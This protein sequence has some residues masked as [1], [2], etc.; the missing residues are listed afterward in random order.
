MDTDTGDTRWTSTVTESEAQERIDLGISPSDE[1]WNSTYRMFEDLFADEDTPIGEILASKFT[2]HEICLFMLSASK[3]LKAIQD[4]NTARF[5]ALLQTRLQ[6]AAPEIITKLTMLYFGLPIEP[7]DFSLTDMTY[8]MEIREPD[9][10]QSVG[11]RPL[12]FLTAHKQRNWG[13]ESLIGKEDQSHPIPT[14]LPPKILSNLFADFFSY[15]PLQKG[16]VD[17]QSENTVMRLRGGGIDE[18]SDWEM[19]GDGN[20]WEGDDGDLSYA[21]S[22]DEDGSEDVDGSVAFV[23]GDQTT[24]ENAIRRLLSLGPQDSTTFH[25]CHFAKNYSLIDIIADTF[26]LNTSSA[27]MEY[28]SKQDLSLQ[29]SF[30]IKLGDEDVPDH[31]EPS[32]AQSACE[33]AKVTWRHH[34]DIAMEPTSESTG[35]ISS[36]YLEFPTPDCLLT[37]QGHV[38][39]WNF[40]H[41]SAYVRAAF[42]V[43][44]GPLLGSFHH[45]LF[46]MDHPGID[47]SSPP[48]YGFPAIKSYDMKKI[49]SFLG[50]DTL[51]LKCTRL[52]GNEIAFFLPSYYNN[53]CRLG[54]ISR[55]EENISEALKLIW[56]IISCAF[57][58]EANRL[59][60]IRLL[61]GCETFG[62][63]TNRNQ[64]SYFIQLHDDGSGNFE[65]RNASVLSEFFADGGNF[66]LLYPEWEG[67]ITGL[68]IANPNG[69]GE[70]PSYVQ[71]PP[72]SSTVDEFRI[73]VFELMRLTGYETSQTVSVRSG[74]S[75]ISIQPLPEDGYI[76]SQVNA[77]CFFI[78]FNT[79]DEEWF[80]IRARISTPKATVR[81]IDSEK[82]NWN[83][84]AGSQKTSVWGPRYGRMA[85]AHAAKKQQKKVSWA[86]EAELIP[87]SGTAGPF[88]SDHTR[89]SLE[90]NEP[91]EVSRLDWAQLRSHK[92]KAASDGEKRQKAYAT[93]PSIFDRYGLV[94]WP[95]NSGIQIPTNAPPFEHM[96]RTGP[97][98]PLVSKAILTPTEQGELQ[99]V[100]WDLRNL[101]LKRAVRCPYDGCNFSYTLN[102]ENAMKKHLKACHTARKCMWCDDTLYE[103]WDA[104]KIN[105]HIREKHKDELMQALGVSQ[106]AI[107]LFDQEGTLSVPLRR[108][109][110]R[111]RRSALAL[112]SEHVVYETNNSPEPQ[113]DNAWGFCDCCGRERNYYSN[114]E[115]IYHRSH[116]ERSTFNDANCRFCTLCGK[117]VWSSAADAHKSGKPDR[118]LSHC[119]H[120]VDDTNGLHCSGCGFNMSRLP[121][122]GRDQHQKRCRGFGVVSGRFCLYC[123]EEFRNTETQVD[124][125][126]NKAHMVACYRG[127]PKAI[128]ML[129]DPEEAAFDQ[130]QN[131]LRLQI[132]VAAITSEEEQGQNKKDGSLDGDKDEQPSRTE[133]AKE[134]KATPLDQVLAD[135]PAVI[136]T[137]LQDAV[138]EATTS[139]DVSQLPILGPDSDRHSQETLRTILRQKAPD[140][141][142][143]QKSLSAS[144]VRQPSPVPPAEENEK[145]PDIEIRPESPLFVSSISS[146]AGS[147]AGSVFGEDE[148]RSADI[149]SED[150]L[151]SDPSKSKRRKPRGRK[152]TKESDSNYQA[153]R[154]DDEEELSSDPSKSKHRKPRGRKRT[155]EDDDNY[156]AEGDGDDDSEIDEEELSSDPSKSPLGRVKEIELHHD[157]GRCCGIRRGIGSIERLPNRS[158]W[159]PANLMPKP[160][161]TLRRK[162]LR[163]YPV[164]ARTIYP[165]NATNANGTYWRSDPNNESNEAWW[166]IPWPPFR[167]RAPLPNGWE[168]PDV[169]DVPATGRTRQQ[170]QL[171]PV[172]DPTYRQGG[173][174]HYSDDEDVDD[175][176]SDK[177]DNGKRKRKR[178]AATAKKKQKTTAIVEPANV[179]PANVGHAN[180]EKAA[181]PRPVKKKALDPTYRQDND[182]QYSDDENVDDVESEKDTNGKRKRKRKATAATPDPTYR[183]GNDVR[184]S[185]E[186]EDDVESD[187]DTNGKRKRKGK[188]ITAKKKQKTTVNLETAAVLQPVKKRAP[189]KAKSQAALLDTEAQQVQ[190]G[191]VVTRRSTRKRQKTAKE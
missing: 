43:V 162:F 85:E 14:Q 164:Y 32:E 6:D 118:Q 103:H 158:G 19:P 171:K 88:E 141:T 56:Q 167:G 168:A 160:L 144:P 23:P 29:P 132:R 108:V 113:N 126:R 152:R 143:Q 96:L 117:P 119:S 95:A 15:A 138:E 62:P 93:Q 69:F 147:D 64:K 92:T 26:P 114:T 166:N 135:S 127:N 179:E 60:Y 78:D 112:A 133:P 190:E 111:L 175:V 182:V 70:A 146:E 187:K 189:K 176:E 48:E 39:S 18:D 121:Q 125:D 99:R 44:L 82:W 11:D 174:V 91:V 79:T 106:A 8:K 61:D 107:R 36:C 105:R 120:N 54:R 49:S 76:Y 90:G 186:D 177:D 151:L 184:Y 170:F 27:S 104:A 55:S 101:C 37:T 94:P 16:I 137:A 109:K 172:A 149:E 80:K 21:A 66:A 98:M 24:Y 139:Q 110:K 45:A 140:N 67:D 148:Q 30:F 50:E 123:G 178:K 169:V 154:D 155:R 89:A 81:I 71:I 159:I 84:G 136:S 52:D 1:K 75:F 53:D 17:Q 83:W 100:A 13:D 38:N 115:R 77:P 161:A 153:E 31:W 40:D 34:A 47:Y 185:D 10:P 58:E 20:D 145:E 180:F 35:P 59:R 116:C 3:V 122:A 7:I 51:E 12:Q 129:E 87:E 131:N 181:A 97:R 4:D 165:L 173:D 57:G 46:H 163:R 142:L 188:A 73:R 42:E 191:E 65:T 183:Q 68:S 128:A 5:N 156:H 63:E 74:K 134:P 25:I 33:V 28:I 157:P 150:E 86:E 124:W 2:Q 72:L 41:Y 9:S 130:Q 22:S 102:D